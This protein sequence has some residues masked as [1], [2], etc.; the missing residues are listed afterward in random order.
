M[1]GFFRKGLAANLA[2]LIGLAPVT[3]S[4][5]YI[6]PGSQEWRD[7]FEYSASMLNQDGLFSGTGKD[8]YGRIEYS[9]GD[10]LNRESAITLLVR[11]L[12]QE[13]VATSQNWDTPFTDVSNWAKPFVG[14]AYQHGITSGTSATTFGAKD[15]VTA[16]QFLTF[17]LQALEYERGVDFN[18]QQ[19]YLLTDRLQITNHY[20]PEI[21]LHCTGDYKN[22]GSGKNGEF[23]RGDAASLMYA[24]LQRETMLKD[25][26]MTI[27]R[28]IINNRT[29]GLE[30]EF[31]WSDTGKYVE[32]M[33][34][35][36]SDE[37]MFDCVIKAMEQ[38]A[39]KIA[40]YVPDY[41][42]M[43]YF[44]W[45]YYDSIIAFT[46]GFYE[47]YPNMNK[48]PYFRSM[49]AGLGGGP[50]GT[51]FILLEVYD[52]TPAYDYSYDDW[53]DDDYDSDEVIR[54][55]DDDW[56]DDYDWETETDWSWEEEEFEGWYGTDA[57]D[58]AH[59]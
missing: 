12:G 35:D 39:E 31:T 18:W 7:R 17:L 50:N 25:G 41:E 28:K 8:Q 21:S 5:E 4:A 37:A 38:G 48:I 6:A 42:L 58:E 30:S 56:S 24:T 26:S 29:A 1:K 53:E 54:E 2:C 3:A 44:Q 33:L 47:Q 52:I 14:Y 36:Y 10:T 49:S 22:G 20:D 32:I 59:S 51:V 19:A 34:R 40:L 43:Q 57:W 11:M 45:R 23:L 16:A 13:K 27:N 15:P 46:E 9:L 55:V